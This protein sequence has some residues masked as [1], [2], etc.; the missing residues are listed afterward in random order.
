[1]V[2]LSTSLPRHAVLLAVAL[3]LVE[4]SVAFLPSPGTLLARSRLSSTANVVMQQ[5]QDDQAHPRL[6][7]PS[8]S[9][10]V[11]RD[12]VRIS[13]GSALA[14]G[15][16]TASPR[17]AAASQGRDLPSNARADASGGVV[18]LKNGGGKFPLMS[19]GLQVYDNDTAR[20]L[21][22]I[23]LEAGVRNFFA[24]VLAGNQKGF[25]QAIKDSGIPREELYIC[26]SVVSNRAVGF[27]KAF[28]ATTKGWKDNMK[29]FSAGNIEYLDQIML[30]YPG[31][32]ASSVL[33]QW[34]SFEEM[35]E[36]G[37]TKSLSVSNFSPEQID[38]ILDDEDTTVKP[39]VNQLPLNLATNGQIPG[40]GG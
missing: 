20:K 8:Q 9:P 33:G 30:D 1:M 39:C 32:D 2:R 14:A 5:H 21:T 36:K 26:G 4:P 25:A 3:M 40:W 15:A 19:F 29:E 38:F 22:T 6:W 35:H 37:L 16:A 18:Q 11:R 34:R 28:K 27:D 7:I 23:A 17:T 12:A 24:S 13:I 10:L 31:K